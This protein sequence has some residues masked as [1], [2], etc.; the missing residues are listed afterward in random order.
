MVSQDG[1][2]IQG[3]YTYT[4]GEARDHRA[5]APVASGSPDSAASPARRP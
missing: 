4:V 5:P 1:H 3:T 2:P